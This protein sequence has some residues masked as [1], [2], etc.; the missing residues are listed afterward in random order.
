MILQTKEMMK[1]YTRCFWNDYEYQWTYKRT[2]QDLPSSRFVAINLQLTRFTVDWVQLENQAQTTWFHLNKSIHGMM[3]LLQAWWASGPNMHR[4]KKQQQHES[5]STM[6]NKNIL[7][8]RKWLN[9]KSNEIKFLFFI[10]LHACYILC[11]NTS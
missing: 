8:A 11:Q 10:A 3:S 2:C 1:L 4:R 6:G 7:M 9:K 5:I